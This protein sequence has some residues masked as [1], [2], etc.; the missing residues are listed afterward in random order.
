MPIMDRILIRSF[1]CIAP[2]SDF[3]FYKMVYGLILGNTKK[4]NFHL[5]AYLFLCINLVNQ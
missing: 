2:L 4:T 3:T 5:N 1:F